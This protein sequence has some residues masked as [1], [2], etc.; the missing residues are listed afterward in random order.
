MKVGN[1][2]QNLKKKKKRKID[3]PTQVL[4]LTGQSNNFFLGLTGAS[5]HTTIYGDDQ[6][7]LEQAPLKQTKLKIRTMPSVLRNIEKQAVTAPQL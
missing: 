7:A 5:Y 1:S 2:T 3:R 4:G 6:L